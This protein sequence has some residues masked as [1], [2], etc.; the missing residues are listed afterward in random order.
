MLYSN[1]RLLPANTEIDR[2][3]R[4]AIVHSVDASV[5]VYAEFLDQPA[6]SGPAYEVSFA[7]YLRAKYVA[8]PPQALVVAGQQ[9]L[10]F[11]LR[12]R[13]ELFADVPVVHLAASTAYLRSNSPLPADVVGVPVE[14]DPWGTIQLA[15]RLHPNAR[16]WCWLRAR[17][18]RTTS[19]NPSCA[20]NR[21]ARS[22]VTVEFLAGLPTGAV[23][24]RLGELG[25]GDIVYTPGYYRD[26][27]GREFAPSQA[28]RL[29]V[30]PPA[31][32][33]IHR[34]PPSSA[35]ASLVESCRASSR[36]DGGGR[37]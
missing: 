22:S 7:R 5:E 35:R 29:I 3:L 27:A 6:F 15:L 36:W 20:P 10:E 24:K 17:V 4:E 33:S 2:G 14:F 11:V 32:R 25:E 31:R 23:V 34:I 12:E 1:N 28:A 8:R 18:R 16:A 21:A 9:A 30:P 19:G 26:G 37:T 13:A